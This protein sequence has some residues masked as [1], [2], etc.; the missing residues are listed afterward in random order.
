MKRR[1][2]IKTS[3][4]FLVLATAP[5]VWAGKRTVSP[6]KNISFKPYKGSKSLAPVFQVTPDDGHYI[7]TYFDVTP[8]SPSQRY[9]AVTKLP[10]I[11]RMP[12]LGDIAEVCVIDLQEG[13]IRTV[14][15]TKSW[16]PQTGANVNWGATD[17]HLYTNDVIKG[18]S[19]CVRI[20]LEND[21]IK[22]FSGPMYHIA[23]DESCVIGFPHEL[24]DATQLGYGVPPVDYDH[25]KKLPVG[26]AK[27]E[28]IWRTDLKTDGKTLLVSLADVAAKVPEPAPKKD[29]TFYFW[30]SKFNRQGTRIYQVLR[31]IFPDF[32]HYEGSGNPM[33]FTFDADG[34]NIR[35]TS[36]GFKV[37]KGPG[38]H[39]NWHPNGEYILRHFLMEDNVKRFFLF[40][41]D[42]S[43]ITQMSKKIVASGHPSLEPSGRF[44]ITD[45][46]G[47][48]DYGL[49][50]QL[51]LI[52]FS[53]DDDEVVCEMPTI[54]WQKEYPDKV[55]ELDGHPVWNRDFTKVSLQA[56][57][58]GLRQLFVF[59]V[60]K[61]MG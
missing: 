22:A 44:L 51:R 40:K 24:R 4:G 36:P 50:I 5:G 1:D 18:T 39:P 32:G 29:G 23:P 28:G 45:N 6:K 37:W 48:T 49:G 7:Q 9:F 53:A 42:G 57:P 10:D 43:E 46:R 19:V 14:Y 17:R 15:K 11:K 59:D 38:G 58:K 34:S 16:G 47:K 33:V 26:A 21:D 56:A 13:T 25:I 52:D 12:L 2:F 31:C 61:L 30:H 41:Y 8:W 27:D 55:W 3:A 54:Q 35:F 20:D 60:D